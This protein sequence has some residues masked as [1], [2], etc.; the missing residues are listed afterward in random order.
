VSGS[1]AILT[2]AWLSLIALSAASALLAA[3]L[4]PL[5][6]EIAGLGLLAL[7]FAKARVIL[8]DYLGLRAAPT[9]RKGFS[10]VMA[11]FVAG[12]GGLFLIG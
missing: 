8:A 3:E 4:L 6:Q 2:R 11:L 10:V 12:L 1:A 7:A 9:W 5:R